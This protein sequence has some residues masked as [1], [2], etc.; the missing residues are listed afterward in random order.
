MKRI[1]EFLFYVYVVIKTANVVI[2][3]CCFVADGTELFQTAA[4]ATRVYFT[5]P[6]KFLIC[7]VVISAKA[8]GVSY[9]N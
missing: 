2:S 9:A 1:K 7:D 8:P 5:W 6:I 4:R 3:R